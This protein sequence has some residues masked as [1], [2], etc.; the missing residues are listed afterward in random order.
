MISSSNPV[1]PRL[2]RVLLERAQAERFLLSQTRRKFLT[3]AFGSLGSLALGG[4]VGSRLLAAN[5]RPTA[6]LAPHFLTHAPR[7]KRVIHLCMAGGP[8]HLE[9]FDPKPVL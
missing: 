8:S 5:A 6:G 3:S 9:S 4:M 7:A 1:P 2:E